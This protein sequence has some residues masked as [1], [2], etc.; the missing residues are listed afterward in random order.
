MPY[1]V[2]NEAVKNEVVKNEVTTAE[3]MRRLPWSIVRNA[4]NMAFLRLTFMGSIFVLFLNE[5]GLSK[6]QTGFL[7]S[8]LPFA[9]ALSLFAAPRV[10]R[11]GF[12]RSYITFFGARSLTAATLL[13]TPWILNRFGTTTA[14]IY[15]TT[16]VG[17]FGIFRALGVTAAFPWSKE[18]VPDAVRGKYTA[19]DDAIKATMGFVA[20]VGAKFVLESMDGL[21]GFMV[22]IAVGAGLGLAAVAAST[23]IPGGEA[24]D[25]ADARPDRS[26]LKEAVADPNFRRYLIG[27]GLYAAAV[28]PMFAFL[29]LFMQEQVGLSAGNVVLLQAGTLLGGLLTSYLWGWSADRYGSKP[30][31]L[32][33]LGLTILLPLAWVLMPRQSMWSLYVALGIA[34]FQGISRLGYRAGAMRLLYVNIVPLEKKSDYMAL[35]F[36]WIGV[37]GGLGK[38]GAGWLIDATQSLYGEWWIFPIDPYLPIFVL[39]TLLPLIGLFVVRHVRTDDSVSPAEFVRNFTRGNP[40][41]AMEGLMGL[42]RAKDEQTAISMTERLG[43]ADSPLAADELIAALHDPRFWVRIEALIAIAHMRPQAPLSRALVD[44]LNGEDPVLRVVAAW[45]LGRMGD[46]S[47]LK[48]LRAGLD[49]DSNALQAYSVRSLGL[50]RDESVAPRLLER[51]Q[52]EEDQSLRVAYASALGHLQIEEAIPPLLDLLHECNDALERGEIALALARII[53]EERRF[54]RLVQ[55][56]SEDAATALA[57]ATLALKKNLNGSLAKLPSLGNDIEQCANL[58]GQGKISDGVQQI[59]T[60]LGVWPQDGLRPCCATVLSHAAEHLIECGLERQEYLLLTL[61]SLNQGVQPTTPL[62]WAATALGIEEQ[63]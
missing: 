14:V 54:L 43:Q 38:L 4:A 29:P 46:R 3:K 60:M 48:P 44:V 41:L 6:S 61:H 39:G 35:Y 51:L 21:S 19:I 30:V 5:L 9:G 32:S 42:H 37:V 24:V 55:Q 1:N 27:V 62:T 25:K 12:K 23:L 26:D 7:L 45:A 63:K 50:L 28:M 8:L 10:A 31:M 13:L 57:Q 47:A 16:I 17:T 20:I 36:A 40:L 52:Q 33:G 53:G 34:F 18:F 15:V 56:T 49:A 22:L 58:L 11:F 2:K 59:H